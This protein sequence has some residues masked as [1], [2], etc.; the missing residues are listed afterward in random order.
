MQQ[1]F[2]VSV[3]LGTPPT[4]HDITVVVMSTK[5][6]WTPLGMLVLEEEYTNLEGE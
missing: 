1:R 2:V 3:E 5:M 6:Q 4:E